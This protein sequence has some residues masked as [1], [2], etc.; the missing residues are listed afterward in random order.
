MH[1]G[2]KQQL[3]WNAQCV[4]LIK[5]K[6][7]VNYKSVLNKILQWKKVVDASWVFFEMG[8]KMTEM[9]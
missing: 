1:G 6:I 7:S 4:A 5:E 2:V 3:S 8:R 9:D